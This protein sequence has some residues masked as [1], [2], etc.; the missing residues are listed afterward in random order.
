MT[1]PS[2]SRYKS[3]WASSGARSRPSSITVLPSPARYNNQKPP[4]PM[5]DEYGS[6]TASAPAA[7]T[8]ASKAFPPSS[9][10]SN[11]ASVARGCAVATAALRVLS[12]AP[13]GIGAARQQKTSRATRGSVV[14]D[15]PGKGVVVLNWNLFISEACLMRGVVLV[16]YLYSMDSSLWTWAFWKCLSLR[17]S[18]TPGS[19]PGQP[20]ALSRREREEPPTP[21]SFWDRGWG[22]GRARSDESIREFQAETRP[23]FCPS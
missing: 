15:V 14:K 22:E 13:A 12:S 18:L 3:R 19:C 5:P 1:L 6:T 10:I 23:A 9:R 16:L 7:A 2:L 17:M 4:P 8:A 11:A 21:L 20:L